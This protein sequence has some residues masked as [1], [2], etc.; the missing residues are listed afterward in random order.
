ML[1]PICMALAFLQVPAIGHC[2]SLDFIGNLFGS[3]MNDIATKVAT[4]NERGRGVI[5]YAL[6]F[7]PD[8]NHVAALAEREN[9]DIWDWRA[10]RIEKTIE[11]PR[12][13]MPALGT[14]CIQY[15]PDGRLLAA[16]GG[17][18]L[19]DVFVRF[20]RTADWT[21]AQ[22]IVDHGT[23]SV[24]AMA[25]TPN[26]QSFLRLVVRGIKLPGITPGDNFLVHAMATGQRLWSLSWENFDPQELAVSPDGRYAAVGGEVS[27][28]IPDPGRPV[29]QWRYDPV[30]YLVDLQQRKVA[31]TLRG[32]AMGSIAWNPDGSRIAV[33]GQ[34]H[35]EIF[36]V[37]SGSR[38]FHERMESSGRMHVLFTPDGKYLIEG[39][40]NG[41]GRGLGAKIWD[42]VHSK[43]LQE[44]VGGDVG[45]IRISR[46]SR[47]LAVGGTSRIT[48]WQI[49]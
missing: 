10:E 2:G 21:V 23:G 3:H 28:P 30:I 46:N 8:A 35:V 25:F 38:V 12:G 17:A 45:D 36:E 15:S 6:D 11:M 22:D 13:M 27:S 4:L 5:V 47:F 14:N 41:M 48:I 29:P 33:A 39:D 26:G 18:G 49:K 40:L 43:L 20:W 34:L 37:T 7:S 24:V 42:I 1:A 32:D 9:I 31:K 19:G 16:C 44:V